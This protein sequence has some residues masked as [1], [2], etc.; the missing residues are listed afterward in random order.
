MHTVYGS[1]LDHAHGQ[2]SGSG[3]VPVW[4]FAAGGWGGVGG[5][6]AAGWGACVPH[7]SDVQLWRLHLQDGRSLQQQAVQRGQL[8]W[9]RQHRRADVLQQQHLLG[10]RP[11]RQVVLWCV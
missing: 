9:P 11:L 3:C 4:L 8:V 1:I 5:A 6:G 2:Q 10:H 7:L